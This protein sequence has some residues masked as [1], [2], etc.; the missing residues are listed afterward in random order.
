MLK[1]NV[2]YNQFKR[3]LILSC[4]CLT[5]KE[6]I[7]RHFLEYDSDKNFNFQTRE[8]SDN[9]QQHVHHLPVQGQAQDGSVPGDPGWTDQGI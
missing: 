1:R 4:L 6:N 9:W 3:H 2:I 5:T 8:C 7:L